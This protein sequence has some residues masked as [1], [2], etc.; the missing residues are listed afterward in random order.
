ML[1]NVENHLINLKRRANRRDTMKVNYSKTNKKMEKKNFPLVEKLYRDRAEGLD[2]VYDLIP[3][4]LEGV[5][6]YPLYI[7]KLLWLMQTNGGDVIIDYGCENY[8]CKDFTV[9]DVKTSDG[10]KYFRGGYYQLHLEVFTKKE[11]E[12]DP[13]SIEELMKYKSYAYRSQGFHPEKQYILYI[14]QL[15][16]IEIPKHGLYEHILS[17][18]D[19]LKCL[20]NM[21]WEQNPSDDN[22]VKYVKKL[23]FKLS[24]KEHVKMLLEAGAKFYKLNLITG[25]YEEYDPLDI[26]PSKIKKEYDTT[27]S[28]K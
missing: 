20:F 2:V 7:Q 9:T 26:T 10:S 21:E 18:Q 3:V 27:T 22:E 16:A 28:K 12:K 6:K 5:E 14:T 1:R 17:R 19:V 25:K 11:N 15:M 4:W 23:V 13:V 24:N 8:R